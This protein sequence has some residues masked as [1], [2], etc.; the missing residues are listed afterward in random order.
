MALASGNNVAALEHTFYNVISPE[1]GA[2]IL[3]S[4]RKPT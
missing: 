3:L 1:G 4:G 2:S